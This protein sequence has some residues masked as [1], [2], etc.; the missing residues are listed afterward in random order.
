MAHREG[1]QEQGM[2]AWHHPEVLQEQ[3]EPGCRCSSWE[4]VRWGQTGRCQMRISQESRGGLGSRD[5]AQM[6]MAWEE[7]HR[8]C[9]PRQSLASCETS[10]EARQPGCLHLHLQGPWGGVGP[11]DKEAHTQPAFCRIL[12]GST[13]AARVSGSSPEG[14][15]FGPPIRVSGVSGLAG[16]RI[17][18]S[19]NGSCRPLVSLLRHC[20]AG[21]RVSA[22][23]S[24]LSLAFVWVE[25]TQTIASPR[26]QYRLSL[27][28]NLPTPSSS[29]W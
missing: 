10:A 21:S 27:R 22:W 24:Q 20:R 26:D 15:V 5:V 2:S 29:A 13:L 9:S 23:T 25:G 8:R 4:E 14:G 28:A 19:H 17:F 7:E 12:I 1:G 18:S 11:G 3:G 16:R 6:S